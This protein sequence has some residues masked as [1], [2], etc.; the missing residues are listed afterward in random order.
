MIQAD[1]E[2]NIGEER[3]LIRRLQYVFQHPI[4]AGGH[5][6]PLL[7]YF[8]KRHRAQIFSMRTGVRKRETTIQVNATRIT[9]DGRFLMPRE[10]GREPFYTFMPRERNEG[11]GD[12]KAISFN[13][14]RQFPHKNIRVEGGYG[15]YDLPD[16]RNSRF[17]KYQMPSYHQFLMN[18]RYKFTGFLSGLNAEILYVYKK[19]SAETYGDF[20]YV[21]NKVDMQHADIILNYKF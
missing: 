18:I 19:N 9:A 11:A 3:K 4:K 7:T 21:I 10:W 6:V 14:I 17:N 15:Y 16:V 20:R 5:Q 13:F 2:W 1:G 8:D 12:V